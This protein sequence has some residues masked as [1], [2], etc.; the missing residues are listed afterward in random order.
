MANPDLKNGFLTV[1]N[2]IDSPSYQNTAII[3]RGSKERTLSA[4]RAI[5][6]ARREQTES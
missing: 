1:A 3:R 6:K 2:K 5:D 4:L